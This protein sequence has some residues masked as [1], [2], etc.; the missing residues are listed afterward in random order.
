LFRA[1][2]TPPE[3]A[4]RIADAVAASGLVAA[5]GPRKR[6]IVLI[7]G[8]GEL[9]DKS[10]FTQTEAR[11]YLSEVGVPLFVFRTGVSRDDGWP[12]GV[13]VVT[14][15]DLG[16]A[17]RNI[18]KPVLSQQVFWFPGDRAVASFAADLPD[19]VVVAGW[20]ELQEEVAET[21]WDEVGAADAPEEIDTL[22]PAG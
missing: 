5:S 15:F 14:M 2:E 19:G 8:P 7:L 9:P 4:R 17:L 1:A 3:G 10:L 20:S 18:V 16:K 6:A 11:A 21:G 13:K 12:K 22:P